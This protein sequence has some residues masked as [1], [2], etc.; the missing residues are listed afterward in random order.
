MQYGFDKDNVVL[1][2]Y[3]WVRAKTFFV[4]TDPPNLDKEVLIGCYK[5]LPVKIFSFMQKQ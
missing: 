3:N 1:A 4:L 2:P 5:R